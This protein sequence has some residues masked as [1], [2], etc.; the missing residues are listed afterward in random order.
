MSESWGQSLSQK[1]VVNE[2]V[3]DFETPNMLN[4]QIIF[5]EIVKI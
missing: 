4:V 5:F 3:N 2:R 1:I